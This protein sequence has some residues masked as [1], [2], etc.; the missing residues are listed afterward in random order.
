MRDKDP[1]TF[2]CVWVNTQSAQVIRG[3]NSK[4]FE[5]TTGSGEAKISPSK[6]GLRL[7]PEFGFKCFKSQKISEMFERY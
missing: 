6:R 4:R 1:D 7:N 3:L 5:A 2:V